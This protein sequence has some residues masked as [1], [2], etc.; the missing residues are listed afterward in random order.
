MH[1]YS[2]S[3]NGGPS[4]KK[5][6][7]VQTE[8][9]PRRPTGHRGSYSSPK[10]HS[11]WLIHFTVS[12]PWCLLL[13]VHCWVPYVQLLLQKLMQRSLIQHSPIL[14]FVSLVAVITWLFTSW[15]HLHWMRLN[16]G[17]R[18]QSRSSRCRLYWTVTTYFSLRRRCVPP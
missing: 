8:T 14:S 2:S 10:C 1:R 5:Y 9:S 7:R 16:N 6:Y 12:S 18:A 15:F 13:L 3:S 4:I 17:C 11:Q